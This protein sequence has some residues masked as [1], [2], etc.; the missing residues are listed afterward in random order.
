[1]AATKKS[2]EIRQKKEALRES[3]Q[4]VNDQLRQA[5]SVVPRSVRAGSHQ[6]AVEWKDLAEQ[7][8]QGGT[9]AQRATAKQLQ[10]L[11]GKKRAQLK[12][13]SGQ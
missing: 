9:G 3:I 2:Q 13:L 11:L 8:L 7:A 10:V 1:M 5:A 6:A 4:Q 12:R